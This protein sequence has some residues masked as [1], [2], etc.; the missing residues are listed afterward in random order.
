MHIAQRLFE[1]FINKSFHLYMSLAI[2]KS[3]IFATLSGPLLVNRQFRAAISLK[4]SILRLNFNRSKQQK[5]TL[6]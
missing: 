4:N 3:A 6:W 5:K 2:P 1:G